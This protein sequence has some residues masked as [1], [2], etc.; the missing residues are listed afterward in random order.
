MN[1]STRSTFLLI[2][3][4][5]LLKYFMSL[6]SFYTHWNHEN[7]KVFLMFSGSIERDKLNVKLILNVKRSKKVLHVFFLKFSDAALLKSLSW[8]LFSN[9]LTLKQLAGGVNSTFEA[10]PFCDFKYCHMHYVILC[11]LKCHWNSSSRSEELLTPAKVG[12]LP[13]IWPASLLKMSLFHWCFANYLLVKP[14]FIHK[15]NIG[16]KSVNRHG[17]ERTH[18]K[19]L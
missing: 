12:P 2:N 6:V 17:Q 13:V 5:P 4:N 16:Q 10:L 18:E 9:Y 11:H 19:C 1:C 8:W 15:L 14:W 3:E 7:T